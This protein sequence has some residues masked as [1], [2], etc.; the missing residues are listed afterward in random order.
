MMATEAALTQSNEATVT[1][2]PELVSLEPSQVYLAHLVVAD[3]RARFFFLQQTTT[4]DLNRQ[5]VD[6]DGT[7]LNGIPDGSAL[8]EIENK[9][10]TDIVEDLVNSTEVSI[11]GGSDTEAS[12]PDLSRAKD[13][14]KGH[15]RTSS[16]AK[17]PAT[18]KSVSVNRTFLAAKG[19]PGAA[20]SKAPD[21]ATAPGGLS[22]TAAG[23]V[24]L[25]ARPRLVA[26]TGSGI[27]DSLSRSSG[28]N[29]G[30]P[31]GVPDPSV[32]WNKNKRKSC[33]GESMLLFRTSLSIPY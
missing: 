4:I 6:Y 8:D 32:V 20:P 30:R 25:S 22:S 24:A 7:A 29:G 17:K 18:F 27:R 9:H 21:K 1:S 26:K 33:R 15:G 2:H 13:D 19:A 11:S 3:R 31:A 16:T 10:I 12:R 14:D 28:A 5:D 23:S